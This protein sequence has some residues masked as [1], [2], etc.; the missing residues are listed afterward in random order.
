MAKIVQLSREQLHPRFGYALP[1]EKIVYV[2]GDL[3]RCVYEFVK[4]HELYHLENQSLWWVL[5]E[6]KANIAGARKHPLGFVLCMAM[7]L[8]PYRLRY[9]WER[10]SGKGS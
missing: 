1:S 6:I 2:R 3:P 8:A 7:S 9:Y 5:R 10:I 4:V